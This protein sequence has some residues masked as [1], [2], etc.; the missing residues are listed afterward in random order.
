MS[1]KEELQGLDVAIAA[2]QEKSDSLQQESVQLHERRTRAILRYLHEEKLLAGTVWQVRTKTLWQG[3]N[4]I[5]FDLL[6]KLSDEAEHLLREDW[7][8][9]FQLE[10]GVVIRF[11]DNDVTL[12]VEPS[13]NLGAI[14]QKYGL[15]IDT[16]CLQ[17]SIDNIRAFMGALERLSE[18]A[19]SALISEIK[20]SP[21][22]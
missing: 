16:T 11:D 1:A 22:V 5:V 19:K 8:S 6:T 9:S 12:A 4:E 15:S 17:V 14:A 3:G 21:A 18:Q 10:E 2:V 20:S 7:H 13:A